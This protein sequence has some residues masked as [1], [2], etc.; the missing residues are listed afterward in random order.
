MVL[1]GRKNRLLIVDDEPTVRDILARA[2]GGNG[3]ECVQA[4]DVSAAVTQLKSGTIDLVLSDIMMPGRSGID[5]LGEVM[6]WW[7]DT[8]VIMLTAVADTSTAVHAMRLGAHDYIIKPFNLEEVQLSVE[9]ALEKRELVLSNREHREFLEQKVEEQTTEIRETSLGAIQAL[10]EALEAKDAYTNGHSRRVTEV[11]VTLAREMGLGEDEVGRIRLAGLLHDIGKIGVPEE[12]LHKPG[13]LSGG[14]F[15]QIKRHSVIGEKI[16]KPV[17]KDEEILAMVRYHHERYGGSGYPE[18]IA[19]DAIPL[20]ARL[21]AVADAYDA[22]TSNRP[23]RKALSPGEAHSQLLENRGI[24]FD[25]EAVDLFIRC[26]KKLPYCPMSANPARKP[27][28]LA[29]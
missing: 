2:L 21:M 10:V 22:M 14:E 26:E 19:G 20:G 1:E 7:P 6:S 13:K 24:Q 9:R 23:Y 11:T 3:Y 28:K 25:P 15:E 4:A 29:S 16:L 12:I 8:G 5:L 18:G 17:I 27:D